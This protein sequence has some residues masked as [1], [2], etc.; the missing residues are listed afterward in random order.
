MAA[1]AIPIAIHLFQRRAEPV[2]E[3]AAMRYLRH[4]PVEQS[5][6]RRLRELLLLA[7]RI[8]ALCLLAFAFARPYF[9]QSV[10]SLS[11]PV[12][13]VLLDTSVSMTAPGQFERAKAAARK[14]LEDTPA[15]SAVGVVAFANGADVIAPPSQ[16]RAAALAALEKLQPGAG[17][18]RYR[19]ALARA[20]ETLGDRKGRF[21]VI[22]DLQQSG[23][24]APDDGAVPDRVEVEVVDVN[25]PKGNVAV[26]SLRVEGPD[27][28]ALVRNYSDRE[29]REQVH[30]AVDGRR[31]ASVPVVVPAGGSIEAH[32][33]VAGRTRGLL[34]ASVSD[35]DGYA[36]DNTRYAV[37]DAAPAPTVLAIT[38]TGQ[39]ADVFYL[40]RALLV[41]EETGG[42]RF[43]AVSGPEFSNLAPEALT[44]TGTIAVL[45]AATTTQGKLG[46][47]H[48]DLVP[49]GHLRIDLFS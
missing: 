25:G 23:W 4:A 31:F 30:F 43:R 9:A 41:A 1:A 12:T 20:A 34:A 46:L 11:A 33:S 15:T 21:V 24:D 5:R 35:T 10:A 38:A 28:I 39:P 27:A 47:A 14:A 40:E 2:I 37:L 36:A 13:V 7:L 19:S 49:S 29:R 32:S 26:G 45:C 48:L 22:T 16:D 18:T 8:A 6:R 17:A 42:F 3:F 44:D